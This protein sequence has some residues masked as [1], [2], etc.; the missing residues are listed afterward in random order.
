MPGQAPG[1]SDPAPAQGVG[2]PAPAQE[3]GDQPPA[4]AEI[5][6]TP[7]QAASSQASAQSGPAPVRDPDA[8]VPATEPDAP[9]LAPPRDP[10]A[11]APLPEMATLPIDLS[12]QESGVVKDGSFYVRRRIDFEL[13]EALLSGE[14]CHVQGPRQSGKS[15]LRIRVQRV[16]AVK[17]ARCAGIDLSAIGAGLPEEAFYLA[18]AERIARGAR[19][20]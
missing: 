8:P 1:V 19:L 12:F 13:P 18:L 7:A 6:Q 9:A 5:R 4:E 10:D 17:G 14:F 20:A 3:V 2:D 16:L 11:P 15:S